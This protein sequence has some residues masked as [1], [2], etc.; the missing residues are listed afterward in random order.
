MLRFADVKRVVSAS[1]GIDDPEI[2]F[3]MVTSEADEKMSKGLFI[4]LSDTELFQ[5]IDKGAV[6]ALWPKQAELPTWLPNHFPLFIADNIIEAVLQILDHY[7]YKT[8]QEEWGTM[9][10]FIFRDKE[11]GKLYKVT[12]RQQYLQMRDLAERSLRLKGGE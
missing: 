9:T 3:E 7:Y 8:K 11:K 5:A 4:A 6:G 1:R 10:N 2:L 12:T